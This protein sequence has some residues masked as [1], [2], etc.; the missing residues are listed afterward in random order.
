MVRLGL[1]ADLLRAIA[2]IPVM[3]LGGL[4]ANAAAAS[5]SASTMIVSPAPTAPVNLGEAGHFAILSQ[6]GIT[7]VPSSD[8]TGNVGTSPITG[9]ADHLTCAEVTGKV[10]S[11]DDAGPAP[12]NIKAPALLN[13]AVGDMQT[14][15]TDA[16]GR[17]A[18][19]HELRGGNIGGLTLAPGVYNWTTDVNISTNVALKGGS[20]A[21]WIFQIAKNLIVS[22]GKTVLL[23]RHALARNVFW[24][25]AGKVSLGTTSHFEGTI[26]SKTLIAMKTG[27]SINGRML[28]QTAV[29]LQMDSV[30]AR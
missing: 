25:V 11:V 10:Y 18:T 12:C 22:G 15:Y 23:R 19:I 7:D 21:V 29:T 3:L 13:S 16:A 6:S 5:E 2:A 4:L 14:A 28:S 8:V 24:Q 9:A 26:L 27:G 17:P 1:N 20:H 30:V